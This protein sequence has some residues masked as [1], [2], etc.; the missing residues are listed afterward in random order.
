MKPGNTLRYNKIITMSNDE[1]KKSPAKDQG[2]GSF[3]KNRHQKSPTSVTSLNSDTAVPMLR[4]GATNNFDTFK[5]KLS[6]VSTEKYKNLGQII[7]DETYYVPPVLDIA[8]YNL[9]TD[10]HDIEKTRLREAHK[11]QDKELDDMKVDRISMFAYIISKLSKES[12]DK[13][14]GQTT[15]AMVEADRDPLALWLLVKASHQILTTSKV[16]SIIKKTARKEYAACKQG[17]YE[18]IVDYKQKFDA[19]LDAFVVSRNTAPEKEDVAMDFMYGLDNARWADFKAEIVNDLTKGTLLTQ[20]NGLNKMYILASQRVVVKTGKEI[21]GG[22]T[23]ATVDEKIPKK[24]PNDGKT[25]EQKQA[26]RLAKM[27][28][29]NCGEKGHPA[30]S[31][32]KKLQADDKEEPPMAGLTFLQ[33]LH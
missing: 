31:C 14:Q 26:K 25:K 4:L 33:N 18:H 12:L 32:P 13:I 7:I 21:P 22:A 10:S 16:A 23:F 5:K 6:I 3:K 11:H 28:C 19:R 29:F 24:Q 20:V 8:D 15:W 17:P 2:K 27:K 30:K 9:V 1:S